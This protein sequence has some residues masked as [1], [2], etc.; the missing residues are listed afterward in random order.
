MEIS[1]IVF[2]CAFMRTFTNYLDCVT[3]S[4]FHADGS[5]PD[6][7]IAHTPW[8]KRRK[9]EKEEKPDRMSRKYKKQGWR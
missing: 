4:T 5:R 1:D 9:K 3:N 2:Y 6:S 7:S 8:K